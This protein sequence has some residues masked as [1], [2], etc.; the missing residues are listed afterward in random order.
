MSIICQHQLSLFV[1]LLIDASDNH[2][3]EEKLPVE[4]Y[5]ETGS[6]VEKDDK[7]VPVASFNEG[8]LMLCF[9]LTKLPLLWFGV[10]CWNLHGN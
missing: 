10:K 3:A 1:S 7:P 4:S 9:S 6:E 5:K 8:M 2:K